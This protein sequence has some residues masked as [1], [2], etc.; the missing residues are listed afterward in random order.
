M[1]IWGLRASDLG[2]NLASDLGSDL[3]S[4]LRSDL[5]SDPGSALTEILGAAGECV[6]V[7][8]PA[9]QKRPLFQSL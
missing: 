2:S 4:D 5:G 6:D 8:G 3:G 1:L 9:G 7:C